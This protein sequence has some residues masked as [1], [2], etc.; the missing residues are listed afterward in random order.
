VQNK[1]FRRRLSYTNYIFTD[2]FGGLPKVGNV[3]FV[4]VDFYTINCL[5]EVKFK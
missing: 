4:A 1:K 2:N 5:A 3:F